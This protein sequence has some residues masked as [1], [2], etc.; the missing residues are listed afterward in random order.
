MKRKINALLIM[1]LALSPITA[2]AQGKGQPMKIT[3]KDGIILQG[4][5]TPPADSKKPTIVMMHDYGKSNADFKDFAGKMKSK[6]FGIVVFDHRGHG[7]SN[8]NKVGATVKYEKLIAD[9]D[10]GHANKKKMVDDLE[11]VIDEFKKQTGKKDKNIAVMG[12]GMSA[13]VALSYAAKKPE[14]GGA[15]LLSLKPS[16]G[17]VPVKDA[18][19][20]CEKNNTKM[21][22]VYGS[23]SSN[24]TESTSRN[25]Y[26][27]MNNINRENIIDT[28]K[29]TN[30]S[31]SHPI[32]KS[33]EKEPVMLVQQYGYKKGADMLGGEEDDTITDW[34]DTYVT[35]PDDKKK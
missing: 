21:M 24:R 12:A 4:Y 1:F 22:I 28:S 30:G 6:G 10:K 19:K 13:N 2:L 23:K 11:A 25:A 14:L 26:R 34:L 31:G 7:T 35:E 20:A 5:Y 32:Y 3:T 8:K 29:P 16:H 27:S 15:I 9:S 18:L 33:K 17:G